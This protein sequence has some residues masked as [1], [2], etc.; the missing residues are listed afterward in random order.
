MNEEKNKVYFTDR[1]ACKQKSDRNE[2]R[3][4]RSQIVEKTLTR[5]TDGAVVD[6]IENGHISVWIKSEVFYTKSACFALIRTHVECCQSEGVMLVKSFAPQ[7]QRSNLKLIES[8][9]MNISCHVHT[10]MLKVAS[11]ILVVR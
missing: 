1:I 10:C 6:N 4:S 8:I 5:K 7:K 2:Q 9:Y 11:Q 3:R